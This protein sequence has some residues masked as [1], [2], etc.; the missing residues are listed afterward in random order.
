LDLGTYCIVD[1]YYISTDR[2]MDMNMDKAMDMD[3]GHEL[4]DYGTMYNMMYLF[5]STPNA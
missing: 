3:M 2:D 5:I 1:G 4:S